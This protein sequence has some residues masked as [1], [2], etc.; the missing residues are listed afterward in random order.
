M[1]H[2]TVLDVILSCHSHGLGMVTKSKLNLFLFKYIK[3]LSI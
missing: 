1:A 2:F 3:M